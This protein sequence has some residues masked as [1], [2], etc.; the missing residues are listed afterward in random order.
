MIDII[1]IIIAS[2]GLLISVL[3]HI[4]HSKCSNC[5]EIDTKTPTEEKKILL[6][7]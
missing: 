5:I 6:K 4:R 2:T 3:S 7:N 1:S